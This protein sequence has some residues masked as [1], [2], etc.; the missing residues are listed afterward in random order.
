ME[1]AQRI[2]RMLTAPAATL[3]Q[4]DAILEGR[5]ALGG[6]DSL[7]TVTLKE[8]ANRLG[9]SRPTVYRVVKNGDLETVLIGGL[10]RIPVRAL[11]AYATRSVRRVHSKTH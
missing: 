10:E 3:E 11:T 7:R 8:A 9:V 5:V 2:Q 1:V 4:V 6:D